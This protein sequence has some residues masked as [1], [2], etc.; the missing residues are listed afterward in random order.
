MLISKICKNSGTDASLLSLLKKINPEM[1][2]YSM[3]T[4]Y[5]VDGNHINEST[6]LTKAGSEG[7]TAMSSTSQV[8][9][10]VVI[11]TAASGLSTVHATVTSV[12]TGEAI[13]GFAISSPQKAGDKFEFTQSESSGLLTTSALSNGECETAGAQQCFNSDAFT[14]NCSISARLLISKINYFCVVHNSSQN[15]DQRHKR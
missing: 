6:K 15:R 11:T 10:D 5:S 8:S 13:G 7:V 3:E 2:G 14:P 9:S 4:T 1:S 12:K